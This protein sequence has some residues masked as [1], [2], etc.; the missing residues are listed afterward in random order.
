MSQLQRQLK[1]VIDK[2]TDPTTDSDILSLLLE[3]NQLLKQL[4]A[5]NSYAESSTDKLQLTPFN[6]HVNVSPNA[7]TPG[8]VLVPARLGYEIHVE[9]WFASIHG[10]VGNASLIWSLGTN[11]NPKIGF[12]EFGPKYLLHDMYMTFSNEIQHDHVQYPI[13]QIFT[14]D[15]GDLQYS[16]NAVPNSGVGTPSLDIIVA[17]Q[18]YSRKN[19]PRWTSQR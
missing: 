11:L 16:V 8:L 1:G 14:E 6:F 12:T 19:Q 9:T 2:I 4:V 15:D 18:Y 10:G 17:G 7:L 5:Y 13:P 3:Q